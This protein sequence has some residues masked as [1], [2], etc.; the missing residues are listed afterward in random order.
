MSIRISLIQKLID[1]NESLFF[2]PKLK[3]FYKKRLESKSIVIDV[4]VNKGQSIE[5]FRSIDSNCVIHGFEP[6]PFL[7]KT[8]AAKYSNSSNIVLNKKGISNTI[9]KLLFNE[10]VMHETSTFENL[11]YNS[12]YLR[13][14]ASVLGIEEKELIKDKYYVDV[15]TLAEYINSTN[16]DRI[17][18][19]KIDTE[20]HEYSCIEGL[21]SEKITAF[22]AFIQFEFHDDDMY[23][24]KDN[25]ASIHVLLQKNNFVEAAK[26][27][28]G[29]GDIYEI[30]YKNRKADLK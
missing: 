6:N 16:L 21:F 12:H 9:G 2:Y 4:G 14:K 26:I 8:L 28:H 25:L 27:K 13:K 30:I 17:D 22:I 11:N 3:S 7:F 19:V 20:G 15:T 1:I 24:R 18:V 10:N 29:F 5:F 23:L